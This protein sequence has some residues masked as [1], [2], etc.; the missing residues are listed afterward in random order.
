[1]PITLYSRIAEELTRR[2]ADGIYPVGTPMPGENALVEEFSASRQTVR[3][4]LRQL[5]D[6][7]LVARR[8][9]IGTLV[10]ANRSKGSFSQ[11]LSSL[12]D[13]VQLA[14]RTPRTIHQAREVVADLDL[15]AQ[16]GI[17]PGTRWL[18]M[19]S[20]RGEAGQPPIV[21]T[22]LYIDAH[23]KGVRKFAQQHPDRLVS[24]IIEQRYGRRIASVDQT[25]AACA[26]PDA[27]ARALQV[28]P[29]SPA[30]F[31]IRHYKDV[32]G[33]MV[34]ASVS[35]HPAERYRFSMTLVRDKR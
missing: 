12:E 10:Q 9:G 18:C 23:Y 29:A 3:A 25:I 33:R 27:V 32:A 7:G 5:Q 8:R 20:T 28:S 31:I 11:S 4:A 17:R 16:L 34:M 22:D 6:L 21:W 30:L 35:Y 26:I 2:I 24:D 1:M 14:V 13:L 19:S 15:A